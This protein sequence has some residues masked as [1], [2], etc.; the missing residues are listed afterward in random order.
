MRRQRHMT[1]TVNPCFRTSLLLMRLRLHTT[2]PNRLRAILWLGLERQQHKAIV[3]GNCIQQ[4][5]SS[6]HIVDLT[7]VHGP[8]N[9]IR[10]HLFK[11]ILCH[12]NSNKFGMH[13]H[14]RPPDSPPC[15]ASWQSMQEA[16]PNQALPQQLL[17]Y[18][19]CHMHRSPSYANLCMPQAC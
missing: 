9:R 13:S 14:I 17:A 16:H 6:S 11:V 1:E 8:S 12:H 4:M 7:P 18:R 5:N 19:Q 2:L 3:Q 15:T 10:M